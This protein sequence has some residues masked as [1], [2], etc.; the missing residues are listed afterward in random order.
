MYR[1]RRDMILETLS[2]TGIRAR[3]PSASLYVWAEVP[4]GYTSY[5]FA[6]RLLDELNISLTPGSAFGPHGEGYVRISLGCDTERIGEAMARL[7]LL[8]L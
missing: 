6:D 3:R 2:Q 7:A 4:G 8:E 1:R 5:S